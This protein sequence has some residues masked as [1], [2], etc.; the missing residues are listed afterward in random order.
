MVLAVILVFDLELWILS[1]W[2]VSIL[3]IIIWSQLS[4]QL[5]FVRQL[6]SGLILQDHDSWVIF[7]RMNLHAKLSN[8]FSG[9][10]RNKCLFLVIV[11]LMLVHIVVVIFASW[12]ID[13]S[14]LGIKQLM[15][16]ILKYDISLQGSSVNKF[17]DSVFQAAV[18]FVHVPDKSFLILFVI[19][20]N[21]FVKRYLTLADE[22]VWFGVRLD[23]FV[24][25]YLDFGKSQFE[26]LGAHKIFLISYVD[27]RHSNMISLN[28]PLNGTIKISSMLSIE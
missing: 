13:G 15:S 25:G 28:K 7:V 5:L 3:T 21:E 6:W 16:V 8:F 18:F 17:M 23:F 14:P 2:G 1:D 19:L 22:N 10:V 12:N 27:N 20:F 4:E 11:R 9:D 26:D 24:V